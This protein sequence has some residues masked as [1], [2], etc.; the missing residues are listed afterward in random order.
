M[1][2]HLA[3]LQ[4]ILLIISILG[5]SIGI[6]IAI[7]KFSVWLLTTVVYTQEECDSKIKELTP[8]T[9]YDD[10]KITCSMSFAR[11]EHG[12]NEIHNSMEKLSDTL[13]K[14]LFEIKR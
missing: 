7:R 13:T 10:H 14:L 4:T 12:Q 1:K 8:K 5:G 11:L 2:E 9:I 6:V 3:W